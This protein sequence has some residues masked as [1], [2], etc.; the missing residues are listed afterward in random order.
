MHIFSD[1]PG[2]IINCDHGRD[3]YL[4]V[5]EHVA[6]PSVMTFAEV[7]YWSDLPNGLQ[8]WWWTKHQVLTRPCPRFQRWLLMSVHRFKNYRPKGISAEMMKRGCPSQL[9]IDEMFRERLLLMPHWNSWAFDKTPGYYWHSGF[10]YEKREILVSRDELHWMSHLRTIL[11]EIRWKG[12]YRLAEIQEIASTLA[13][14]LSPVLSKILATWDVPEPLE[15]I[16]WILG[17][18]QAFGMDEQL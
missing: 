16:K 5:F 18:R 2:P 8:R 17:I 9:M 12:Q 15:G 1:L 13:L 10:D 11:R 14:D 3:S 7:D 6:W 4:L